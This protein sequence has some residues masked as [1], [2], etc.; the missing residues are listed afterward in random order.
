MKTAHLHNSDDLRIE[1]VDGAPISLQ[2]V[3]RQ[4][5]G[6]R[7][8]VL[9]NPTGIGIVNDS[10]AVDISI[11]ARIEQANHFF[12]LNAPFPEY[13]RPYLD[14]MYK[15]DDVD[16]EALYKYGSTNGELKHIIAMIQLVSYSLREAKKANAGVRLFIEEPETQLH[17]KRERRIMG[18]L[19]MIQDKYYPESEL[20][21]TRTE[22]GVGDGH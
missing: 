13:L 4:V 18:M 2:K 14:Y 8:V 11:E 19:K 7:L 20:D 1:P 3:I 22:P 9:T 15:D 10:D 12:G 6:Q 16:V 17:P 21:A 5:G